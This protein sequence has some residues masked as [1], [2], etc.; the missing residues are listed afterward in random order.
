VVGLDPT[1]FERSP[2]ELSGG[3]KRKVA[4]AGILA[5]HP[6]GPDRR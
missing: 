2:F 4:I 3:E 6:H 5:I 1:F